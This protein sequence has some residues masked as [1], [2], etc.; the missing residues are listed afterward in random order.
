MISY[1]RRLILLA[2]VSLAAILARRLIPTQHEISAADFAGKW[3]SSRSHLLVTLGKNG[4]W[5]VFATTGELHSY[6][7]W[8]YERGELIW[9]SKSKSGQ[10][11]DD[12]NIVLDVKPNQFYLRE[13]NGEVTVFSRAK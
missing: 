6:G 4:E 7:V 12:I 10:L 9:T 5:E 2:G 8:R 1:R 13:E 3:S 11:T